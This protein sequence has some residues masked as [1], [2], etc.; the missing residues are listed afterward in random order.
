MNHSLER[1]TLC[2]KGAWSQIEARAGRSWDNEEIKKVPLWAAFAELFSQLLRTTER[3][4]VNP[5]H[6]R[7]SKLWK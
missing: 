7:G 6:Q 4:T 1:K 2:H 5:S 3:N